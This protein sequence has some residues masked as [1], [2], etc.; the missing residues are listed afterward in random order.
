MR[1][2][3]DIFQQSRN[4]IPGCALRVTFYLSKPNFYLRNSADGTAEFKMFIR[5]PRLNLL[6]LIPSPGYLTAVTKQLSAT[7]CKY[8]VER[9][10][11]S[12]FDIPQNI[13]GTI[14]PNIK[15]GPLP[16]VIFVALVDSESYHGS[17]KTS[18]FNFQHFGL[19]YLSIEAEG[20]SYP[21]KPYEI[22]TSD[23]HWIE[24]YQTLLEVL[25]KRHMAFGEL[26]FDYTEWGRGYSI[27]AA[28]LTPGATGRGT[29]SL[30]RQ[31]N[32]SIKLKF[33]EPTKKVIMCL[34]MMVY[35]NII[36]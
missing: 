5:N 7:T 32:L 9:E 6:H 33:D 11:I 21:T 2:C 31:G 29:M 19:N 34:V 14:I 8:H 18:P 23:S 15:I 27:F 3:V 22:R 35:D 28:D 26:V 13:T 10:T 30:V 1:P 4:L 20:V 16:K 24:P 12:T 25:Q 17:P 36:G